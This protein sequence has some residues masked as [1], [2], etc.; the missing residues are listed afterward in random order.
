MRGAPHKGL[1]S[2]IRRI[3]DRRSV[4][5]PGRPDRRRD[6]HVQNSRKPCRCHARTVAGVTST[7]AGRHPG[8]KR[9]N[10][11]QR[12]RSADVRWRRR[13][14][15]RWRTLSWWRRARISTWSATRDRK[16]ALKACRNGTTT[17][18]TAAYPATAVTST[19]T[20]RTEFSVGTGGRSSLLS[21]RH[22]ARTALADRR[23]RPCGRG[24]RLTT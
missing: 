13:D 8:H 23:C 19:V 17:D 9:D 21:K 18:I 6:V 7:I 24:V 14:R 16:D 22:E 10:Q 1:A 5:T 15:E 11:T 2:D 3:S 20:T 4:C 12:A